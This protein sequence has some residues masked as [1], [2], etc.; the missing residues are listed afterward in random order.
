MAKKS[1]KGSGQPMPKVEINLELSPKQSEDLLITLQA[2]FEQNMNR[3]LGLEWAKIEA[4]LEAH[5]EKL[6]S[7]KA[8]ESTG[9]E[10]DVV[11]YDE[12][13]GEYIFFDCSVESPKGRRSICAARGFRGW[14]RA[15]KE[16]AFSAER[17]QG[18]N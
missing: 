6:A 16:V 13:T 4:K 2:R 8:M 17:R 18:I 11:G 15:Q 3:H 5:P 7:L 12:T 10:P 14:L 1:A 9:G